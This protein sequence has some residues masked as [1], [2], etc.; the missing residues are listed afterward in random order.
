MYTQCQFTSICSKMCTHPC[1]QCAVHTTPM[2]Q[3]HVTHEPL[4]CNKSNIS[5]PTYITSHNRKAY[6]RQINSQF[7]VTCPGI[8]PETHDY[9]MSRLTKQAKRLASF[10]L[11]STNLFLSLVLKTTRPA[12]SNRTL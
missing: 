9:K 1:Y 6:Q 8:E 10:L 5:H 4:Y 2:Y 7:L 12:C 3:S 11:Y